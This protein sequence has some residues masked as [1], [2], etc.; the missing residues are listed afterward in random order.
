MSIKNPYN[1]AIEIL[2][3]LHSKHPNMT[4][5]R[6]LSVAFADYGDLESVS[7]KE[8]VFALEKYEFELDD[9]TNYENDKAL[10]KIIQDGMNLDTI[11]D[12]E[13]EEDY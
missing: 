8:F 5:G 13:E 9:I 12:D 11:L 10:D 3:R 1:Q 7:P 4:L 6:H 2:K